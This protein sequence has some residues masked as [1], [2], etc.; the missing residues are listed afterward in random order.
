MS[1]NDPLVIGLVGLPGAGKTTV[2]TYLQNKGFTR[3]T[4]SDFI[5]EEAGKVDPAY[6]TREILQDYG[7]K[8]RQDFGP[9][10]LAQRAL[11]KI[12]AAGGS[13]VVDGIRNVHEVDFF[14]RAGN[15]ILIA[16]LADTH[17]RFERLK[18]RTDHPFLGTYEDFLH[19]ENREDALGQEDVGLRVQDC[20]ARADYRIEN[21][22]SLEDLSA[23]LDTILLEK[24]T[25]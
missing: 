18:N 25:V 9:D 14:K 19:L 16:I 23:A 10:V 8:M 24:E 7:N 12:Q 17:A 20:I 4:L 2:A 6:F 15:F 3:V 5:R 1:G 21:V 22:G 13:A 11:L